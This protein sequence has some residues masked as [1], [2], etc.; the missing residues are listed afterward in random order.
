MNAA[1][2]DHRVPE[3]QKKDITIDELR[4]KND[5][6][7]R[8]LLRMAWPKTPTASLHRLKLDAMS[9]SSEIDDDNPDNLFLTVLADLRDRDMERNAPTW[10]PG[11]PLL[12]V[13]VFLLE[14]G[15]LSKD[16]F[17][18][19]SKTRLVVKAFDGDYGEDVEDLDEAL[20]RMSLASSL[21]KK[22]YK[23][24]CDRVRLLPSA[25]KQAVLLQ[26]MMNLNARR[27]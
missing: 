2:Q 1:R 18:A 8:R 24:I 22:E 16:G 25:R 13:Y 7:I 4:S 12:S 11:G 26:E 15:D 6:L 19:I 14:S 17:T 27:L 3:Y 23:D 20:M 21:T 10:N 5:K 9:F